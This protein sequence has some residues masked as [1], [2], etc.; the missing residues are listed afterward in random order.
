MNNLFP[1]FFM[2]SSTPGKLTHPGLNYLYP[3]NPLKEVSKSA[4]SIASIQPLPMIVSQNDFD[5]GNDKI[6]GSTFCKA[7]RFASQA[8]LDLA[9]RYQINLGH[10]FSQIPFNRGGKNIDPENNLNQ[11]PHSFLI[12]NYQKIILRRLCYG[13][14]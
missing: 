7:I 6:Q 2:S 10:A 11:S 4:N 9:Q 13:Y 8:H 12:G 3:S 14:S 1:R 5:E